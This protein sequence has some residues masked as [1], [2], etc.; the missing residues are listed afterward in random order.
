MIIVIVV[1]IEIVIVFHRNSSINSNTTKNS[2]GNRSTK[3]LA[4]EPKGIPR[5]G[6]MIKW[7]V[8]KGYMRNSTDSYK[9]LRK[10][11]GTPLRKYPP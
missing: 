8:A 1:V 6:R 9:N 5:L 4:T 7:Y 2:S 3:L 11:V 10:S